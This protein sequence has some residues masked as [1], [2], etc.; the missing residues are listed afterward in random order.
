M[1][2]GT[3]G[4]IVIASYNVLADAY[5]RPEYYRNCDAADFAPA[6]R[7]PRLLER[8]AGLDADVLCL[9]E[10][11]AAMFE[12]LETRL[13]PLG[14]RGAWERKGGGKPD[15]CATFWRAPWDRADQLILSFDDGPWLGGKPSGHLALAV[16]LQRGTEAMAVVNTHLKWDAPDA[17]LRKRAG[18]AQAR[19]LIASLVGVPSVILCGDFNAA[20]DSDVL[21]LFRAAGY[22]DAHPASSA[23]FNATG[24]A[25]K[26]DYL[27]H[28]ADLAAA[29]RT[30]P[31]ID[32]ATPLPSASEPSDHLP[33]VAAFARP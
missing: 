9:Q 30:T 23:T 8:V 17:P 16:I 21:G 19:Q 10:V 5:I 28:T 4:G 1:T 26:I 24:A 27:L 25:R 3:P 29:P 15:G 7:H 14:Y 12:R 22:V 6:T 11:E 20:P 31:A 13:R 32:A 2:E 18:V 33:L